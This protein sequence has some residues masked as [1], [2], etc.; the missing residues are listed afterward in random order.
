MS[1]HRHHRQQNESSRSG[2][3]CTVGRVDQAV[4]RRGGKNQATGEVPYDGDMIGLS[5]IRSNHDKNASDD[6]K[7]VD[8]G[9]PSVGRK[10]VSSLN[11][12]NDGSDE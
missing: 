10:A 1:T 8:N 3:L 9:P 7:V 2:F 6:E 5:G 12:G 4:H 11:L